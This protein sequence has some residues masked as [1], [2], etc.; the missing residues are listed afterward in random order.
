MT[1][2]NTGFSEQQAHTVCN[3]IDAGVD[4]TDGPI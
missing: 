3:V 2:G 4:L 1:C